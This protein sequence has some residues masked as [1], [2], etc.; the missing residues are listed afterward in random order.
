MAKPPE[1]KYKRRDDGQLVRLRRVRRKKSADPSSVPNPINTVKSGRRVQSTSELGK[2]APVQTKPNGV[3][4]KKAR[5]RSI[6]PGTASMVI[7]ANPS[8]KRPLV[9]VD[10]ML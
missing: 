4:M 10:R 9:T 1:M 8:D 7:K 6:T 5:Y 3:G 2:A